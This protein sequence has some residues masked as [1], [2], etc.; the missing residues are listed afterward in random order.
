MS[1]NRYDFQMREARSEV[2]L[3]IDNI[4]KLLQ[5]YETRKRGELVRF[6]SDMRKTMVSTSCCA[7]TIFHMKRLSVVVVYYLTE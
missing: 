7:F 3:K 2:V 1:E 6:E 4:E 5:Y